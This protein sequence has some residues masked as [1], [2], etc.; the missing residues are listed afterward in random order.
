VTLLCVFGIQ[1]TLNRSEFQELTSTIDDLTAKVNANL[2]TIAALSLELRHHQDTSIE[3]NTFKA[4][5]TY[6]NVNIS[7]NEKLI[8]RLESVEDALAKLSITKSMTSENRKAAFELHIKERVLTND[9]L[10]AQA[11][12]N[13]E[14]YFENHSGRPIGEYSDSIADA[15]HSVDGID[16]QSVECKKS[17]CKITYNNS[18]SIV[19]QEGDDLNSYLA[20]KLMFGLEGQAVELRY[21]NDELGNQIIY[22]EVK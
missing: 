11:Y 10:E 15:I 5:N 13:T 20:D 22:A 4:E 8:E 7:E 21:A 12:T 16:L 1:F 2:D 6:P 3:K 14:N 18:S 9:I 17:I 19:S